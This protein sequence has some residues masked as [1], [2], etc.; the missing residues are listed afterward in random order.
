MSTAFAPSR[1]AWGV[2]IQTLYREVS[3]ASA[4][5]RPTRFV[6]T[7]ATQSTKSLA[8][9]FEV[10]GGLAEIADKCG[11]KSPIYH[12]ALMAI[13]QF[14]FGAGSIPIVVSPLQP[15]SGQV[16]E[17]ATITPTYA[18]GSTV[19]APE[20][21]KI[22]CNNLFEVEF[23]TEVGDLVGDICDKIVD[24]INSVLD[25][26]LNVTDNGTTVGWTAGW[27]GASG[28]EIS[29]VFVP[30][31]TTPELTFPETGRVSGAGSYDITDGFNWADNWNSHL[32][33]GLTDYTD[34][35]TL[36]AIKAYGEQRWG[37]EVAKFFT[38][39]TGSNDDQATTT[40][41][42]DARAADRIN[43][44]IPTME[45]D[46][47]TWMVAARVALVAG[48]QAH[49]NP[50]EA[51]TLNEVDL[52]TVPHP[53]NVWQNR[54]DAME[55][56]ATTTLVR[57]GVVRISN[58]IT[59]YHPA[60]ENP[61]PYQNDATIQKIAAAVFNLDQIFNN[62]Q[63]AGRP[64]VPDEQEVTNPRAYKPSMAKASLDSLID[65]LATDCILSDPEYAKA[66]STA[67]INGSNPNRL[68]INFVWKVSGNNEVFSIDNI[69]SFYFGGS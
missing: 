59:T 57:D 62:P 40:A 54:Q 34:A 18:S 1:T 63:I 51:T 12:E 29:L 52:I 2:A 33:N 6:I 49:S 48:L 68:D 60:G 55:K 47:F 31:S 14:G 35:T 41:V 8:T 3:T 9:S 58:L 27:Y 23:T 46:D 28:N 43:E 16:A 15:T 56:G 19:V 13:P 50:A 21:Y 24:A 66:N 20:T 22:Q 10:T 5:Y 42:T 32:I 53:D 25:F 17:S 39:Y 69:W 26:P 36:D 64:L 61:P 37:S 45:T 30:P 11:Y 67:K 44:I 7:G 38:A 4:R 65:A